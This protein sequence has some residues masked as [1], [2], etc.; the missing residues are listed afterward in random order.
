MHLIRPKMQ[1]LNKKLPTPQQK[2]QFETIRSMSIMHFSIS[3][4]SSSNVKPWAILTKYNHQLKLML[5]GVS[6]T[7][8][9]KH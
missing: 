3:L 9:V 7:H 8:F 4:N 5:G 6:F 2:Y 1:P